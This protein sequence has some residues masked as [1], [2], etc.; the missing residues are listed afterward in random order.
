MMLSQDVIM[1]LQNLPDDDKLKLDVAKIYDMN[2]KE[3]VLNIHCFS[4]TEPKDTEGRWLTYVKGENK[5]RVKITAK[6]EQRLI[7]KLYNIYF[8]VSVNTIES[9]YPDWL[10]KRKLEGVSPRTVA[11]NINHWD[12]Y[13]RDNPIVKIPIAK[14]DAERIEMFFY[15]CINEYKLKVKELGNMKFIMK[16]VFKLA[17][18]RKIILYNPMND[19]EIKTVACVPQAKRS[20]TSKVY[21]PDEIEKL[22]AELKKELEKLPNKTD[23][24]AIF[25]EFKLGLR[26]GELSALKWEDIDRENRELHIHR[27]ETKDENEH[28]I[29]VEHTKKKSV[30]GDRFIPL[31]DYELKIFDTVREINSRN[32]FKDD[33]FIFCDEKGRTNSRSLD[34]LVRKCCRHAGIE[35]KSVHDMRRTN[36]SEMFNNN[37]PAEVIQVLLGHSDIKT[38]YGYIYDNVSKQE[39]Q[40]I[41]IDS[42]SGLNAF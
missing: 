10:E 29:V 34:N 28:A 25:L 11:R 31:S 9:L 26:I 19:V 39:R 1:M 13:Y 35:C 33:D 7:D 24:Y 38:T 16:E 23:S 14:L 20:D 12:K 17:L 37:V 30:H 15:E 6:T 3:K 4:I 42:I 5:D 2:K 18:R 8:P 22:F 36:A 27:M 21:L 40:K 32:G 41:V